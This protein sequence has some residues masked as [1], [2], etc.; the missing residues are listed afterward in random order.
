V[1]GTV[2][3]FPLTLQTS[4]DLKNWTTIA[5]ATPATVSWSFVHD[6]A[7]ATGPSRF[8]RAFLNP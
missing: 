7:L 8:Y 6:A 4:T 1:L 2:P 3:N 5:T